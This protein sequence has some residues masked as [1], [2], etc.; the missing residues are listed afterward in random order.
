[1]KQVLD[2][3]A[4][5]AVSFLWEPAMHAPAGAVFCT[6]NSQV[7][8]EPSPAWGLALQTFFKLSGTTP[9]PGVT[10]TWKS[11]THLFCC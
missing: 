11:I 7:H 8:T 9:L 3:V 2:T 6:W 4:T 10:L 1:M 5:E